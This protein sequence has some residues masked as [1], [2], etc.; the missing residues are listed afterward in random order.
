MANLQKSKYL[1]QNQVIKQ[2]MCKN[3]IAQIVKIRCPGLN[4]S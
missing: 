2:K 4:K 3:T 1:L